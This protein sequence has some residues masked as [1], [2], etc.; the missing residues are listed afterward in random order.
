MQQEIEIA[1]SKTTEQ[2]FLIARVA[3]V[4]GVHPATVSRLMDGRKLGYHQIGTR[5]IVGKTHPEQSLLQ[6]Y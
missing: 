2:E 4:V 5:R 6:V 3:E 1:A